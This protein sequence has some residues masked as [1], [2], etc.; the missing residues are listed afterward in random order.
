MFLLVL[1]LIGVSNAVDRNIVSVLLEP[2][3]REFGASDAMMGLL[4]GLSFA[5]FYATLGVPIARW[6]D[7]G[8]RRQIISLSLAVW[9]VMTVLCGF[10]RTFLGLI[11]ARFGVGAGEAG[12]V[13]C[14]QSLIAEYY[15]PASRTR[16]L[17]L[18]TAAQ[19]IGFAVGLGVGG[20]VAQTFGWRAA[21]IALG[22]S[23]T[24]LV[25]V[26]RFVL[27]EP[28]RDRSYSRPPKES[29]SG[30]LRIL[31]KKRAYRYILAAIVVYYFMAYGTLAFIASLM[32]RAYG[33]TVGQAGLVFGAVTTAGA[34][35]GAIVGGLAA[36]RL[37]LGDLRWLARLPGLGLLVALPLY[38]GALLSRELRT[39]ALILLLGTTVLGAVVPVM[40]SA[41]HVVCGSSRR[42]L[43][44][45]SA[46]FLVNFLGIGL[47][48]VVSGLLSDSLS[49]SLGA[50]DGLRYALVVLTTALAPAGY[51]M[52]R[53]VEH[54]ESDAEE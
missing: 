37:A 5:A 8:D 50:A 25:P 15:P 27:S 23:G 45:A 10:C 14:A 51:L 1:C 44:V 34:T 9:S 43:S 17:G 22:L 41:L 20:V 39:M 42:A 28:R 36:E 6:A 26:T 38:C 11:V 4:S 35:V 19:S 24:A 29:L 18:F 46:F 12:A 54:L 40:F 32:I 31:I 21:F 13:P 49:R 47:G 7:R 48:P 30:A 3:K 52:L 33:E 53:A 2:I 16:A